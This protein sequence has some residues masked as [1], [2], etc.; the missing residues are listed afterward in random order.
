MALSLYGAEHL[1]VFSIVIAFAVPL[2]NIIS[3]IALEIFAQSKQNYLTIIKKIFKNPIIISAIIGFAFVF[4]NIELPTFVVSGIADIGNTASPI[5]LVALGATFKFNSLSKY[6]KQLI[7]SVFCKLIV[8]PLICVT[9][10]VLVG[11]CGVELAVIFTATGSP[12]AVSSFPMAK[13][14]NANDEL[15]GQI[16]VISSIFSIITIFV[17]V[18]ALKYLQLI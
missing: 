2:L 17:W 10:G 13:S 14:V 15:A 3:V 16:L 12:T 1:P 6:P 9:L 18:S 11:F 5:S 4:L 7:S 8:M